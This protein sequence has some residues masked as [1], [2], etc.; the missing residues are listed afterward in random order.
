[1]KAAKELPAA[2]TEAAK[3]E[4]MVLVEKS[5]EGGGQYTT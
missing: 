3:F 2:I 5:I 1:V 4:T